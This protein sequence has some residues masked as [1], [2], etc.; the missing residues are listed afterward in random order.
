M[1]GRTALSS[2]ASRLCQH[3][4][5]RVLDWINPLRDPGLPVAAVLTFIEEVGQPDSCWWVVL[6]A[7][8]NLLVV[9]L[10]VRLVVL[11]AFGV[12]RLLS[13]A[14]PTRRSGLA[15][16]Q[17]G[18][19][20]DPYV[21][22]YRGVTF[23][24]AYGYPERYRPYYCVQAERGQE[25]ATGWVRYATLGLLEASI[26]CLEFYDNPAWLRSALTLSNEGEPEGWAVSC[27]RGAGSS[28]SVVFDDP[29][30]EDLAAWI[31]AD[32]RS[33]FSAIVALMEEGGP[34]L[35]ADYCLLWFYELCAAAD[36]NPCEQPT[37]VELAAAFR[38][39]EA[40]A[41][42]EVREQ[43]AAG[44]RQARLLRT[45]QEMARWNLWVG[46]NLIGL[47]PTTV[48]PAEQLRQGGTPVS[49]ETSRYDLAVTYEPILVGGEKPGGYLEV[50]GDTLS[51]YVP[52]QVADLWYRERWRTDRRAESALFVLNGILRSGG[53][54]LTGDDYLSWV[55]ATEGEAA[56]V[57]LARAG[58]PIVV[59]WQRV[60][61][62]G[63]A[64][65]FY[66]VPVSVLLGD[67]HYV[68]YGIPG[69]PRERDW[70]AALP[71]S[72]ELWDQVARLH[73][74]V[75]FG[76][77]ERGAWPCKEDIVAHQL[78]VWRM[79]SGLPVAFC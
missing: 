11:A 30:V 55:Y 62:F 74:W 39:V 69:I 58:A 36:I 4:L 45:A 34:G 23:R 66:R 29:L 59:P 14:L 70:E 5:A 43:A 32:Y 47:Q 65:K 38:L 2:V 24:V 37:P 6:V 67:E 72:R 8:V 46:Q 49:F 27:A 76:D 71:L 20:M 61:F 21:F 48:F 28:L 77:E 73:S 18:G 68:G 19:T 33:R 12:L 17:G 25:Q 31:A 54:V 26:E 51:A 79:Y 22:G 13:L 53:K 44:R 1:T 57:A 42:H 16:V 75:V 60:H 35:P 3:V 52:P 15:P 64:S 41:A 40:G 56:L 7:L 50:V 9:R 10:V 78:E 63:I